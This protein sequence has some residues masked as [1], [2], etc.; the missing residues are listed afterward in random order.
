MITNI[1]KDHKRLNKIRVP[2]LIIVA[3]MPQKYYQYMKMLILTNYYL[4]FQVQLP[5]ERSI[6]SRVLV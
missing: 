4:L 5:N 2:K 6:N 1:L 3:Q